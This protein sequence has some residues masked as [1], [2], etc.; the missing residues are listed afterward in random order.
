MPK[1]TAIIEIYFFHI[2]VR[3]YQVQHK[4]QGH[5]PL[6]KCP[7]LSQ[8]LRMLHQFHTSGYKDKIITQN[9]QL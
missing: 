8:Q 2:Q 3:N 6:L 7:K 1:S 5:D 4:D 9:H